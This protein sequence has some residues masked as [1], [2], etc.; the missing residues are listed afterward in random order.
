MTIW[1]TLCSFGTFF[2]VL[3]S[4]TKKSLA[5]L[6]VS[7]F[8]KKKRKSEVLIKQAAAG[9]CI[10]LL[11]VCLCVWQWRVNNKDA[12]LILPLLFCLCLSKK[13]LADNS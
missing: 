7:R 9:K 10:F 1:F 4:C 13:L 12:F 11:S 3:V 8:P 5:T 2:A 6:P